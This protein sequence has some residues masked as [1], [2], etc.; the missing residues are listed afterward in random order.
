MLSKSTFKISYRYILSTLN[1]QSFPEKVISLKKVDAKYSRGECL[2][3][4]ALEIR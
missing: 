3:Q 2:A 1:S 4:Y